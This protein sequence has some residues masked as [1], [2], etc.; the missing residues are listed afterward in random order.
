L[1]FITETFIKNQIK[2]KFRNIFMWDLTTISAGTTTAP[3]PHAQLL[4]PIIATQKK[5]APNNPRPNYGLA[6]NCGLLP[7]ACT[8]RSA[9]RAWT[10][11]PRPG[12]TPAARSRCR[13]TFS[14][15][16]EAPRL[17][18]VVAPHHKDRVS[19]Q[20]ARTG[21]GLRGI[22]PACQI[23][24]KDACQSTHGTALLCFLYGFP[25]IY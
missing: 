16:T 20:S 19:D 8:D 25:K 18:A 13:P 14:T 12:R 3:G 10:M 1:N 17:S 15:V 22:L 4:L 7:D 6:L 9:I 23:R 2:I 5:T 21:G 24:S 11:G